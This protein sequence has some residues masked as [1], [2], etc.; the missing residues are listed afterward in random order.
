MVVPQRQKAVR[1]EKTRP[2][3]PRGSKT[4]GFIGFIVIIVM[5]H[6]VSGQDV[7]GC[8]A[9]RGFKGAPTVSHD[10]QCLAEPPIKAPRM[11]QLMQYFLGMRRETRLG[12]A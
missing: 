1:A 4:D 5:F 2:G 10:D 11:L 9:I 3:L 7:K 12:S 8:E 6:G